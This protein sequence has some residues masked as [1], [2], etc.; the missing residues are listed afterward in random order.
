[1]KAVVCTKYGPPEV[2]ELREVKKPVPKDNEVL[3]KVYATTAH[4]GDTRIRGLRVPG[5]IFARGYF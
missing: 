2:L 3:I 5:G 4:V 1:M